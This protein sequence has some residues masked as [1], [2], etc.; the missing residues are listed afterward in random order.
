MQSHVYETGEILKAKY[1]P[2]IVITRNNEKELRDAFLRRC[3]FHHIQFP[4][5]ATMQEIID[6]HYPQIMQ[7]LVKEAME[8]FFDVR[9]VPGL[10]K[11]STS[12]LIDWLKW[13]MVDDMPEEIL[14]NRDTS[15]A[16]PPKNKANKPQSSEERSIIVIAD[17]QSN[18]GRSGVMIPVFF[19]VDGQSLQWTKPAGLQTVGFIA[20]KI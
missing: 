17:A 11:P 6:V 19:K 9:K 16:M 13:L 14:R 4:D 2:M 8:V 3:F 7:G 5:R 1:R 15:K 10:K 12:E 20:A 18:L